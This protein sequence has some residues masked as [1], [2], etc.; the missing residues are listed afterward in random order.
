MTPETLSLAGKIAI[1]TGAGRESGLGAG[2]A[3]A[4]ARNGA[5]VA[6]NYVND[7]TGPRAAG[8]ADRLCAEFGERAA[9]PVQADIE[10][11]T[12]AFQLVNCTL[13][14][15][16]TDHVDILSACRLP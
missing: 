8:L 9:V 6:L 1:V 12:G 16:R 13:V 4:L 15:F 5:S 3:T 11:T 10:A 7:A 14:A 2:I